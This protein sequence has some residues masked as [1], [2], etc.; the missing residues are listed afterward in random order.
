MGA[1]EG[2]VPAG[3]QGSSAR[4]C[5]ATS[6]RVHTGCSPF[7][8]KIRAGISGAGE[9]YGPPAPYELQH[10]GAVKLR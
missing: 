1:S 5:A 10:H 2:S 9:S 4:L 3:R 6:V 7:H 8:Q